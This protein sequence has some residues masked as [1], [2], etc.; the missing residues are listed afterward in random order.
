VTYGSVRIV[1]KNYN[2][3]ELLPFRGF[4]MKRCDDGYLVLACAIFVV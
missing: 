3:V 4:K 2:D 1:S